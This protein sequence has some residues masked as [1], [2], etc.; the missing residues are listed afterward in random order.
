MNIY[1]KI[2]VETRELLSR[3]ML[4]MY[5]AAEGH[6]VL[7]G[8][9]E[10][11]K[12]VQNNKLHPGIILEK[13]ITPSQSRIRQL[14]DYKKNYSVV[15]SIDEEGGLLRENLNTFLN[16]RFSEKS[17]F[18]T[19]KIFCWSEYDLNTL[20]S[21]FPKQKQKFVKTGNPRVTLW[22]K[23]FQNLFISK[24]IED[25]KYIFI[26]SNFG[27]GVSNKRLSEIVKYHIKSNYFKKKNFEKDFY[28]S[29]SLNLELLFKFISAIN[30][31][32]DRFPNF[33][34]IV[35][36]HPSEDVDNWQNFFEKKSNLIITKKLNHS[37]WI[38]NCN[39]VVHNG[40]TAGV[41]AF[42]RNKKLISYEPLENETK[43]TFANN[44]G[45]TAKNEKELGNIIEKIYGDRINKKIDKDKLNQFFYRFG[46]YDNENF[47]K[48]IINEWNKL[49]NQMLSKRNNLFKIKFINKLRTIK[50]IFIKPYLNPKFPE[51]KKIEISKFIDKIKESD[52]SLKDVYFEQIGP[53]LI[54]LDLMK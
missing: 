35:R 47:A 42:A 11:L 26:S 12:H 43:M 31:L 28:E 22:N 2:E 7:I 10:L 3:L 1:I 20:L 46:D 33:N 5:A 30:Y 23:Q 9:D 4:G 14:E 54:K 48:N 37:D 25:Q 19:D 32:T 17:I 8:D 39:I 29:M 50:N 15:T 34:F 27:V 6:K 44:F 16:S 40:C 45:Y 53:K 24:E 38:E 36:P 41:E 13:S 49:D 21:L 52:S 51:L 18:L